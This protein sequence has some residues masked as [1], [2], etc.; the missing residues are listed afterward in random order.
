MH[1]SLI[2]FTLSASVAVPNLSIYLPLEFWADM[3][4]P[5]VSPLNRR[6]SILHLVTFN[7]CASR[8]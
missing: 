4:G 3:H 8:Q 6:F 1:V 5:I 2:T 7:T